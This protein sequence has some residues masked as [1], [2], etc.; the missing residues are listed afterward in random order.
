[1]GRPRNRNDIELAEL[2]RLVRAIGGVRATARAIG[3][4]PSTVCRYLA[5]CGVPSDVVARLR[6]AE[7]DARASAIG[8][9]GTQVVR[10]TPVNRGLL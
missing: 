7:W 2:Q 6:L 9:Y 10:Q 1:M 5:E 4:S 8:V 3:C